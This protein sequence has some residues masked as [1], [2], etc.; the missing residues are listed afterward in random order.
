[1]Y[2]ISLLLATGCQ[3]IL[4]R[5]SKGWLGRTTKAPLTVFTIVGDETLTSKNK[6]SPRLGRLELGIEG[7]VR[8]AR[9]S[10]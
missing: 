4:P 5:L 7:N 2:I 10:S 3:G 8:R 6:F 9:M 1:M